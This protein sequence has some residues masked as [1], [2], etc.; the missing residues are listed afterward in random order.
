MVNR[1]TG[2]ND[3]TERKIGQFV[4]SG[5]FDS[6]FRLRLMAK[7]I[8]IA[9]DLIGSAGVPARIAEACGRLWQEAAGQLPEDADNVEIARVVE[10]RSGLRSQVGVV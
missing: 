9:L 4:L 6:G 3:A 7:D 1:S 10:Q 5:T 8:G 2:R